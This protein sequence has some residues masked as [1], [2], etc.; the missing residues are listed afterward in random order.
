MSTQSEADDGEPRVAEDA[1]DCYERIRYTMNDDTG[2]LR[3]TSFRILGGAECREVERTL[4]E[5]LLS[6]PLRD[7]EASRIKRMECPRGRQCIE[8]MAQTVAELQSLVA[9]EGREDSSDA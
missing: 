2:E 9:G 4:K 8:T 1:R 3:F 5:Y 7:L 6:R